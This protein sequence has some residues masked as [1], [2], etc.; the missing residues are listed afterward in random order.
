MKKVQ[1]TEWL[2]AK[3]QLALFTRQQPLGGTGASVISIP[4]TP[5]RAGGGGGGPG[6][7][8]RR[9][10]DAL[11]S[12]SAKGWGPTAAK[13]AEVIEVNDDDSDE[14]GAPAN[15]ERGG[16]GD[17]ISDVDSWQ[18]RK[19]YRSGAAV[20]GAGAGRSTGGAGGESG[21][22]RDAGGRG[23]KR[24]PEEAL[25]EDGEE[26]RTV[27]E[28]SV[29]AAGDREAGGSRTDPAR[30][31]P[32]SSEAGSPSSGSTWSVSLFNLLLG[33]G[34]AAEPDQQ[35]VLDA[36]R[37]SSSPAGRPPSDEWEQYGGSWG[38]AGDSANRRGGPRSRAAGTV[39]RHQSAA[40]T[41]DRKS[42]SHEDLTTGDEG[43]R[44]EDD[45]SD[46]DVQLVT[47]HTPGGVG[48][49]GTLA[50]SSPAQTARADEIVNDDGRDN[51]EE[52]ESRK[53]DAFSGA[54]ARGSAVATPSPA[55]APV[56]SSSSSYTSTAAT[57]SSGILPRVRSSYAPPHISDVIGGDGTNTAAAVTAA[58][59]SA[60]AL[61]ADLSISGSAPS[62]S[63]GAA[64]SSRYP[65][66]A[67][68]RSEW[69]EVHAVDDTPTAP[70]LDEGQ[71]EEGG[72]VRKKTRKRRSSSGQRGPHR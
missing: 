66:A 27:G 56:S 41:H 39:A 38:E 7:K 5:N 30:T 14:G 71:Q 58:I 68:S 8:R 2:T 9:A 54:G 34:P 40:E 50:S 6:K 55:A 31:E 22:A 46:D 33:A 3:P 51:I 64:S 20:E 28:S 47:G 59:I 48:R 26:V 52:M 23:L 70:P 11:F 69:R 44:A 67:Q 12:E 57:S 10:G 32:S 24:A 13:A 21:S 61:S 15:V 62:S 35:A 42:P 43:L 29:G 18:G 37:L 60:V 1:A 17:G 16:D 65:R 72:G 19:G 4:P 36:P 63:T 25:D 45:D 49:G 53:R